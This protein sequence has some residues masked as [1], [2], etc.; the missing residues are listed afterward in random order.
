ML[1]TTVTCQDCLS[2]VYHKNVFFIIIPDKGKKKNMWDGYED[3]RKNE[4][5]EYC[6]GIFVLYRMNC[7]WGYETNKSPNVSVDMESA[8][9]SE[10]SALY[11]L[12]L[13]QRRILPLKNLRALRSQRLWEIQ[14]P[15]NG[16]WSPQEDT[17]QLHI[18]RKSTQRHRDTVW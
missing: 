11:H 9:C 12:K 1:S 14:R 15:G 4:S 8:S 6:S 17:V 18:E 10:G 7:G 5:V 13:T 16:Q 3:E 2:S